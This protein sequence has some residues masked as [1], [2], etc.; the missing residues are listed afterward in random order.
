MS[1]GRGSKA[2]LALLLG[3]REDKALRLHSVLDE[4]NFEVHHEE[5]NVADF[6]EYSLVVSFG[7]RHII[8]NDALKNSK[9]EF[10]NLH[11]SF[12]PYNR[13]AH[14]IFWAAAQGNPFGVSLHQIDS[15]LDTGPIYSQKIIELQIEET[16]FREAHGK[17]L[18]EAELLFT[19]SLSEILEGRVS[20]K[21]QQEVL[22]AKRVRDL[23]AEF[24]GWDTLIGP[25]IRRLRNLGV[26]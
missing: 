6:S 12:L 19:E 17:V 22:P 18:A 7:Y 13:G 11:T 8:S 20:P 9:A 2:N 4:N 26:I 21:P 14:P 15:G 3:Y 16:T 1:S 5:N 10:L 24:L 23:P 25:E